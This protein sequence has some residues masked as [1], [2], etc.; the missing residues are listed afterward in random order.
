MLPARMRRSLSDRA[1]HRPNCRYSR[2]AGTELTHV[3]GLAPSVRELAPVLFLEQRRSG[4]MRVTRADEAELV[5]VRN[6][7]LVL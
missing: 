5:G 1:V 3:F 2:L 7:Q 6:P 4:D